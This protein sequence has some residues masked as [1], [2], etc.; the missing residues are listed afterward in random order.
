MSDEFDPH[1]RL[2]LDA[3]TALEP[4]ADFVDRVLARQPQPRRWLP[5][6]IAAAGCAAAAAVLIVV[7]RPTTEPTIGPIAVSPVDASPA[8]EPVVDAGVYDAALLPP[9]PPV[10]PYDLDLA[11][12]QSA[13]LH[14]P[15]GTSRINFYGR[16]CPSGMQIEITRDPTFH[17]R[18]ASQG[19]FGVVVTFE[20]GSWGYRAHCMS[21]GLPEEKPVASGQITVVR[22]D[23]RRALPQ[24]AS[25]PLKADGRNYLAPSK[26]TLEKPLG[27]E[28]LQLRS[29]TGTQKF[30]LRNYL[31]NSTFELDLADGAY[32][33]WFSR[34]GV[35][36]GQVSTF[37]IGLD[38]TG[39][40][41]QLDRPL[42]GDPATP[43]LD[44][45]GV[46]RPGWR[47]SFEG[48][49]VAIDAQHRFGGRIVLRPGFSSVAVRF[50][51][52][53]HGSHYYVRRLR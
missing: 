8:V 26:V 51:H 13:T 49:Q 42:D 50:D 3:W 46:T 20:T 12:G 1:E 10:D 7:L 19:V 6:A 40:Q 14:D 34:G 22:D 44:V 36:I 5:Y 17:G 35:T 48:S 27:G 30:D 45:R 24:V 41:V 15:T 29:S 32:T 53:R 52:P 39:P 11:I 25:G 21:G 37:V 2:V 16:A 28:Q 43:T 33:F 23:G 4:P 18:R 47:V 31:G 9:K 38:P